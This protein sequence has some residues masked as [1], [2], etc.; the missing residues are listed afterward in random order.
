[1][2]KTGNPE[3]VAKIAFSENE[4]LEVNVENPVEVSNAVA[5]VAEHPKGTK[6]GVKL[7]DAFESLLMIRGFKDAFEPHLDEVYVRH[8]ATC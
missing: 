7:N 3:N 5:K 1:M 2:K 6:L 8:G 4:V